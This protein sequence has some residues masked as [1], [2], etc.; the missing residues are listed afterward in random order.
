MSD[1]KKKTEQ[2]RSL[3]KCYKVA[4]HR[5]PCQQSSS[6]NVVRATY[7]ENSSAHFPP[8][9]LQTKLG[10]PQSCQSDASWL[11]L[12]PC[13]TTVAYRYVF[14]GGVLRHRSS[15]EPSPPA[16]AAANCCRRP[17]PPRRRTIRLCIMYLCYAFTRRDARGW[18]RATYF[19]NT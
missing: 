5:K 13:S 9:W 10:R 8:V 6:G 19:A 2:T 4:P 11:A 17:P 16:L 3:M 12:L 18:E 7:I 14:R 15:S 1:R